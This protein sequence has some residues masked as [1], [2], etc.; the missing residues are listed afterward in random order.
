MRSKIIGVFHIFVLA[1]RFYRP[2]HLSP[3]A[4]SS[5]NYNITTIL[6]YILQKISRDTILGKKAVRMAVKTDKKMLFVSDVLP[7]SMNFRLI[8]GFSATLSLEICNI[9]PPYVVMQSLH[10]VV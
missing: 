9:L 10:H 6:E 4:I 7:F 3:S 1:R 2:S 8:D 5:I